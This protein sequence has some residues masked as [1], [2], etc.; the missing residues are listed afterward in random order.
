WAKGEHLLKVIAFKRMDRSAGRH[1]PEPDGSVPAGRGELGA[2]GAE[3]YAPDLV[4]MLSQGED[5]F[6]GPRV[7]NLHRLIFAARSEPPAIGTE[8]YAQDAERVSAF[9]EGA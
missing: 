3:G 6:P 9:L 7:P 5:H 4:G 1:V 8:C 2:V